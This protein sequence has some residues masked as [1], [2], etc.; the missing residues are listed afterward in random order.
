MYTPE[1][2]H[3]HEHALTCTSWQFGVK[4]FYTGMGCIV[5]LQINIQARY[6]LPLGNCTL[7]HASPQILLF[8]LRAGRDARSTSWGP[9]GEW[10][11]SFI[12]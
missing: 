8:F 10:N 7:R 2:E 4:G 1:H 12:E 3:G 9:T 6:A 11:K 5:A